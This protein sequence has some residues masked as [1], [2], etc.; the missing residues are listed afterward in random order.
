MRLTGDERCSECGA[1]AW[2]WAD[3]RNRCGRCESVAGWVSA[4]VF[5][6]WTRAYL[7]LWFRQRLR[8][9]QVLDLVDPKVVPARVD[10]R[11]DDDAGL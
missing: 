1:V 5:H 6:A 4:E 9:R 3:A 7:F 10:P 2:D 8:E 11:H